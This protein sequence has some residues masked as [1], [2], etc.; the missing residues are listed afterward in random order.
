MKLVNYKLKY[1]FAPNRIGMM[2]HNN[3]VDLEQAFKQMIENDD[4]QES[5]C[6]PPHDPETF[7]AQAPSSIKTAE[8][9]YTYI[10]NHQPQTQYKREDVILETPVPNPSK[11]ICTG[12]NYADHIKEMGSE[13]PEFPVL[14][15]KFTNALIGPEDDIHKINATKKLDY[16][17]EL[18]VVIGKKASNVK[19]EDVYDYIAGYTIAND[20]S[21]R[22]LQKRTV[23]WL[24]GK[25]L[26]H[27]TPIGP[28]LV[29]KDELTD[30]ANLKIQSS[31]NGE[32]R[33]S[34][35]T[36]HLIFDIPFL[37]SFISEL[38]TLNPGDIILTGTAD[39]VGLAMDPPQFLQDGDIVKVE[40]EEIGFMENKITDR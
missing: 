16:E 36:K 33:Q 38:I 2:L 22:D 25:S 3:V 35:N 21:A 31:V 39:G 17:V 28:W 9:V 7:Y 15:S 13:P 19:K 37:I 11:I 4:S 40:I 23:Q 34:S 10:Q 18:A 32:V 8:K 5:V 29:T 20:T 12:I 26:D 6:P 24:Q 27:T 1:D 14:F 30:P